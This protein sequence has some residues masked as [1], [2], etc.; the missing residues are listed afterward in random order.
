MALA[1]RLLDLRVR[2]KDHSFFT[3]PFFD[4]LRFGLVQ[5]V[6]PVAFAA[7][8]VMH[9]HTARAQ[10]FHQLQSRNA[11]ADHYSGLPAA[12][13]LQ[14][15]ARVVEVVQLDHAGEVMAGEIGRHGRRTRRQ[16][17][18]IVGEG[19]AVRQRHL[20]LI[21]LH[22]FGA[23]HDRLRVQPAPVIPCAREQQLFRDVAAQQVRQARPRIEP[24]RLLRHDGNRRRGVALADRFCRR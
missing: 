4:Q 24:V 16:E 2:V 10:A 17:Q 7:Q 3:E 15:M 1:E 12:C 20:M 22:P 14:N 9:L 6:G 18:P 5:D 13:Q 11:S 19:F 23:R 21:G 8:E